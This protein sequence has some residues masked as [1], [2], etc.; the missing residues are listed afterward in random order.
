MASA[1]VELIMFSLPS[2]IYLRRLRHRGNNP[3]SARTAVGWRAG[4]PR[5][6]GLAVAIFAV[7]LP[8]T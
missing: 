7:L 2:L 5:Y 6:Y 1:I 8:T 3:A 4:D